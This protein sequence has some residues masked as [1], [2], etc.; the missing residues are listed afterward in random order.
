[1]RLTSQLM[2][3]CYQSEILGLVWSAAL[4]LACCLVWWSISIQ[5]DGQLTS[6]YAPLQMYPRPL[7]T[8]NTKVEELGRFLDYL[9]QRGKAAVVNFSSSPDVLY[10]APQQTRP[11]AD[12]AVGAPCPLGRMPA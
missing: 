1:M 8:L 10:M 3:S 2:L 9:G 4:E 5:I 12:G 7:S 6:Q 11:T